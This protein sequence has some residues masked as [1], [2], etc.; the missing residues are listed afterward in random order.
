MYGIIA[1]TNDG[2]LYSMFVQTNYDDDDF[3]SM[4]FEVGKILLFNFYLTK[5]CYVDPVVVFVL[6]IGF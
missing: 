5:C 1:N 4:S 6:E 3:R 2:F